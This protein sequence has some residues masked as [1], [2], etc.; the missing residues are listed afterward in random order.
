MLGTGDGAK[1][2]FALTKTYGDGED[3]Y[4]RLIARPVLETL[5]VAVDGVEK[6]TPA[7]GVSTSPPARWCLR[8][9]AFRAQARR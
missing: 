8:W 3:A 1:T 2:R 9:V 7:T 6:A 5:R 4:Q